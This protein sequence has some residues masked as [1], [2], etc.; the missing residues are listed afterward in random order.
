MPGNRLARYVLVFCSLWT[1]QPCSHQAGRTP[2]LQC[3]CASVVRVE[4]MQVCSSICCKQT[5][6]GRLSGDVLQRWD[7]QH[8]GVQYTGCSRCFK[9]RCDHLGNMCRMCGRAYSCSLLIEHRMFNE[10]NVPKTKIMIYLSPKAA[11]GSSNRRFTKRFLV[12]GTLRFKGLLCRL[13]CK[14]IDLP[15]TLQCHQALVRLTM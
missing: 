10:S 2:S 7:I 6:D 5:A 8:P 12:F 4:C 14:R 11:V 15:S 3:M 1:M 9:L 13:K